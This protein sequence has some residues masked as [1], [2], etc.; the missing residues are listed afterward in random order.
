M[1]KVELNKKE[2]LRLEKLNAALG[3]L[4]SSEMPELNRAMQIIQEAAKSNK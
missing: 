3:F 1:A 4:P 2:E